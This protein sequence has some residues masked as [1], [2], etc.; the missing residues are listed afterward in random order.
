MD[1]RLKVAD[2]RFRIP[3]CRV[4]IQIVDSDLWVADS[5]CRFMRIA[6]SNFVKSSDL[7][8]EIWNMES[9]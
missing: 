2:C 3:D 9:A 7:K 6:V 8:F 5:D 4:E 1:S